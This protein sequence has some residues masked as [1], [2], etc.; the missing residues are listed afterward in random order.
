MKMLAIVLGL[1]MALPALAIAVARATLPKTSCSVTEAQLETLVLEKMSY[2]DVKIALGCDGVLAS[3][4]DFDGVVLIETYQW[5][6]DAWPFGRF[7]GE[8]INR[9]MHGTS[10]LWLNLKVSADKN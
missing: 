4:Q 5:R 10:K 8:F 3:K 1:I 9:K 2:D 6:G 7:D